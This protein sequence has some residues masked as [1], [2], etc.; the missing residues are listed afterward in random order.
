M[1][2]LKLVFP[3]FH[4]GWSV[5]WWKWGVKSPTMIVLL[6]ISPF[7]VVSICLMYW[8]ASMLGAYILIIVISSSWIDPLIIIR[9][10]VILLIPKDWLKSQ[11]H[12]NAT[13]LSARKEAKR[14][15]GR[16]RAEGTDRN[17][18]KSC[19]FNVLLWKLLRYRLT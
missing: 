7:M 15:V 14:C 11:C 1:Y 2:H 9:W 18:F 6:S 13:S 16:E 5:H 19:N 4:F 12:G 10:Q 8:G 3:Y 17:H